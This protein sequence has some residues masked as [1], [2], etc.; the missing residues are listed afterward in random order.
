VK[1]RLKAFIVGVL[2]LCMA[3]VASAGTVNTLANVNAPAD[4]VFG[5]TGF[6]TT[7]ADMAILG[8]LVTVHFS[9]GSSSGPVAWAATCGALCGQATGTAGNGTWSLQETDDTGTAGNAFSPDTSA[10]HPWTLTN[11][12]TNLA[13]TSVDL[14]GL[15]LIIFDRDLNNGGLTNGNIGTP[16][17]SVGIDYTFASEAGTNAPY[18][19][20]V[21]YSR[22]LQL[23]GAPQACAGT[24]YAGL[25]T[26][27]GCGDAWGSV[28]FAFS[29]PAFIATGGGGSAIWRFFQDTDT[30]GAPEP[31]TLGLTAS[32]LLALVAY[33]KRR[34]ARHSN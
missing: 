21:T 3:G 28:S 19:V 10:T 4:V 27:V 29:G 23:M 7:G 25:T 31:L 15:T 1:I 8:L 6:A 30:V 13:I 12:S 18:T 32:G 17:T 34:A 14:N 22:I 9:D 26:A 11:T 24:A 16:G 2:A 20:N 5:V 33:R